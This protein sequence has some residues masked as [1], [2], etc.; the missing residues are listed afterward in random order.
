MLL[1][2]SARPTW[3]SRIKVLSKALNDQFL[4]QSNLHKSFYKQNYYGYVV[5]KKTVQIVQLD[6]HKVAT[7]KPLYKITS[8]FRWAPWTKPSTSKTAKEMQSFIELPQNL[9]KFVSKIFQK[10]PVANVLQN[11][12]S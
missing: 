11:R 1:D 10:Q 12:C 9:L 7:F 4:S 3:G 5:L 6:L 2:F 8:L